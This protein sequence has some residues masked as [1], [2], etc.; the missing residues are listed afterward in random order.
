MIF[1]K[2]SSL[3]IC[4]DGAH[5]HGKLDSLWYESIFKCGLAHGLKYL[6]DEA[7]T[8]TDDDTSALILR[9]KDWPERTAHIYE[10][11]PQTLV[12][13]E[14]ENLI[15]YLV[16]VRIYQVLKDSIQSENYL[17]VHKYLDYL[18]QYNLFPMKELIINLMDTLVQTKSPD[19]SIMSKLRSFA[20]KV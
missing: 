2:G 1:P 12:D 18:E 13:P 17:L 11:L 4:S 7:S 19:S 20:Y 3:L 14:D 6:I 15:P 8:F 16:V 9:R 10:D 5:A